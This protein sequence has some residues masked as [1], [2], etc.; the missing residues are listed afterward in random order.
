MAGVEKRS[1]DSPD[2][3]RRPDKTRTDVVHL[4]GTTAARLTLEPGWSW[5]ACIKRVVG[6]DSCQLRHLGFVQSGTMRVTHDD[7]TTLELG[8]GETYVIEPGH[9]AEVI[10]DERFIGFEFQSESAEA[11][12]KPA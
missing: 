4:G 10:G 8:R 9:Q 5:A 1:F 12:A 11:Y 3:S 7:G 6:G 2:E